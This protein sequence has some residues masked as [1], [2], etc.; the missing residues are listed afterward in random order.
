M[1]EI[2]ITPKDSETI[3]MGQLYT[4]GKDIY[5]VAKKDKEPVGCLIS[6]QS[7]NV[8]TNSRSVED[9]LKN[10]PFKRFIGTFSI[11]AG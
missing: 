7:G 8:Y 4:Y 2:K 1:N 5:I 9:C 3:Q 11:T 10:E 6:L